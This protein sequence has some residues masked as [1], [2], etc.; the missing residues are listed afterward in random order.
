[1]SEQHV[2]YCTTAFLARIESVEQPLDDVDDRS[3]GTGSSA[4]DHEHDVGV[5]GGN[6]ADQLI[7]DPGQI[8]RPA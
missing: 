3:D 5:D 2:G 8:N 7:L 1:M 4:D 6:L